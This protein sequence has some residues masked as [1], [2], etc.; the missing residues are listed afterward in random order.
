MAP[1]SEPKEPVLLPT[2]DEPVRFEKHIRQLFRERDRRSMSFAFDLG[3]YAD[4][5]EHAEEI[6]ERVRNGSMPCDAP[7]APEWVDT[8]ARWVQAGKP[9]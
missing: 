5:Q 3:T 9:A 4:V 2:A 6:L 1:A 7:W 8:F